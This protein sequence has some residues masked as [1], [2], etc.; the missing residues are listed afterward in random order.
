MKSSAISLLHTK[1][2]RRRPGAT[3]TETAAAVT[4]PTSPTT[5]ETTR[6]AQ[7]QQK[8]EPPPQLQDFLINLIDSPG[9]IDFSSDVSTATRL[10]DG[11]IVIV[12]V[13]EGVC[14]QTHAV[15]RQAWNERMK[16]CLVLNKLDRLILELRL[17]P[18]EAY[19]HL[20]RTLERVNAISSSLITSETFKLDETESFA[21]NLEK[22]WLFAPERGN[23]VFASSLY[24]WAFSI[25]TF[26][27]I[28][29]KKLGVKRGLLVRHLWGDFVFN[30]KTLGVSR[31][32]QDSK[33][34]PMFVSMI[35]DPI[36][37][38]Y[39][40]TFL[41]E[42]LDKARKMIKRLDLVSIYMCVYM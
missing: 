9:H 42:D 3:T 11:A 34:K 5:V 6:E 24:C 18:L 31:Y 15:L 1:E 41:D 37:Q 14:T 27:R 22:E 35:L 12:D 25:P 36:W 32:V 26:A 29:A 10:S 20:Q 40:V 39:E 33:A 19:W 38:L 23:V 28:W 21:D 17:T 13:L 2:L 16:P 8:E 30:S 4:T 7:P